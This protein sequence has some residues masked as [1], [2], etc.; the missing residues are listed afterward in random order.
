MRSVVIFAVI[1]IIILV[2]GFGHRYFAIG[3]PMEKV[4]VAVE[5]ESKIVAFDPKTNKIISTIDLAVEHRGGKLPYAPHNVQVSP[6]MKTI[7]V[8]ANAGNHQDHV[9]AIMPRARAHGD[10]GGGGDS[11]EI[12][13]I[14][15]RYD[16]II[17]RIPVGVG[18]HLAHVVLTQDSFFAY[19]TAQM[20]GMIYKINTKTFIIEKRIPMLVAKVS[21]P[22]EP[23]GMR[24]SPDG[25][26]AYIAALKGKSLGILDLKT[27]MISIIPLGGKAVQAGITPD[28]KI[29]MV[30]LYDTKQLA[31]YYPE[32]RTTK[33]ISLPVSS[34]GPIQMFPTP[35]S[36]FAYLADQGY[37]FG[38]PESEW[39]YK[40]DLRKF[41]VVKEIKAGK[42]PHGVAVSHDGARVYVTNLL[43][44]DV[45]V[46]STASDTE[47]SRIKVGKEPNGISVWIKK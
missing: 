43:S 18:V 24:V 10:E 35:D 47:I 46:I 20:Q 15:A 3:E 12:V 29:A 34:K 41:E 31:L 45:S 17:K 9:S 28:G 38:Q 4:Y 5:G 36:K 40:V 32:T 7:W 13:V 25:L 42:G 23:H 16:S 30:S 14:D 22:Q 33:N 26:L 2:A 37:Y 8:T 27:D 11:D 19:A 21:G 39:V 1:S 44:G 6:D